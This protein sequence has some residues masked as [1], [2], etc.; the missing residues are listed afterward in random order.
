[1]IIR[2]ANKMKNKIILALL[3]IVFSLSLISAISI[4]IDV[5]ESFS[6]GEEISFEY[7]ITSET[8]QEIEYMSNVNCPSA[9]LALLDIK[10]IST[11]KHKL[12]LRIKQYRLKYL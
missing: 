1:M 10:T 4:D 5:K 8:S 2:L 6:V 9:P 7:T 3:G 11:I 12:A